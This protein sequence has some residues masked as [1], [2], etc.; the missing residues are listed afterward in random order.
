MVLAILLEAVLFFPQ[1]KTK[2]SEKLM[3]HLASFCLG[4]GKLI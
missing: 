4:L 2:K 1:S 3:P